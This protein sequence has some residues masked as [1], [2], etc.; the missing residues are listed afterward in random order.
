MSLSIPILRLGQP[1]DSLN[2]ADIPDPRNG[3]II[4]T[5]SIANAGIIRKDLRKINTAAN[6]LR[7]FS[8]A[9]LIDLCA[10]AGDAFINDTLTVHDFEQ[11]PQQYI[12]TLSVTS[13]LPHNMC[14]SNMDKIRTVLTGM[15]SILHGLTRGLDLSVIDHGIGK[16]AG[17]DVSYTSTTNALGVVLPSNSPGVNSIWLPSIALKTPVM[18]KPGR[19]EPWTPLRIIAAMISVGCPQEAFGFYPTDHEGADAI[20]TGCGRA[21]IFGDDATL[22]RYADNPNVNRHGTGRSKILI[23]EDMIDQ[24]E[25]F[26]DVLVESVAAN[27]G[28]SCINASSIFVPRH[29]KAIAHALA[30][31]L[32]HIHPRDADDPEANL[33]AFANIKFADYID[34][35][36]NNGLNTPGAMAATR[37]PRIVEHGGYTYLLPTVI[38]C[39]RVDH[40]LANTEFLFPFTSVVEM[41]QDKML[42]AIG[43]SLVVSGITRDANFRS[44]LMQSRDIN[45]LNL[46]AAPTCRVQWDQPHEGNLFEFLY[47]RRAI[48]EVDD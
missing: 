41:D 43:P 9:E 19:E 29:G 27:S 32:K 45:R 47:R 2:K 48:C 33:S 39:D 16:Q 23:G 20:M 42:D 38:Y 34:Q 15:K 21:I 40:P 36:I 6:A 37:E 18:L 22:Q 1:Y 11:S 35:T 44:A 4:A 46:G 26:L 25:S 8:C 28:R 7:D 3:D 24:W 12:E 17:I 14:R 31:R 10:K 13:G 30:D 5:A